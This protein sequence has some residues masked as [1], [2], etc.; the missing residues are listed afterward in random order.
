[1]ISQLLKLYLIKM[2]Q[3]F[4]IC[5]ICNRN[6]NTESAESIKYVSRT[7]SSEQNPFTKSPRSAKYHNWYKEL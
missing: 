6:Q 1:M 7:S 2:G 3:G 5:D 4:S